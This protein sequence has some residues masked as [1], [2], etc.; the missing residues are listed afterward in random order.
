MKLRFKP[1]QRKQAKKEVLGATA[2]RIFGMKYGWL[3]NEDMDDNHHWASEFP[4]VTWWFLTGAYRRVDNVVEAPH[5]WYPI[6]T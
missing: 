6:E 4:A 2:A 3:F 1:K 5:E